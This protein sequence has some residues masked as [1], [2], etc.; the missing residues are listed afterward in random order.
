MRCRDPDATAAL[1]AQINEIVDDETAAQGGAISAEHGIGITN[2]G[3]LA[4]VADP[5][6]IEL[7]RGIKQLLDPNGLMNPG[8]IFA[9][10]RGNRSAERMTMTSVRLLA[11]DLTGALDTAAEFVGLC[12]PF[13]VTWRRRSRRAARRALRSTAAPA[14][15]QGLTAPRSS[16]GWRRSFRVGRSPTRRSIACSAVPGRPSSAP[17]CAAAI[18]RHAWSHRPFD[19]QDAAHGRPAICAYGPRRLASCR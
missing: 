4:R 15:S 10:E 3:R 13:D 18:G 1:V 8:K 6:D 16:D 17:A 12:G 7:M 2:R 5:L 9:G 19:Y 11:D 14:S